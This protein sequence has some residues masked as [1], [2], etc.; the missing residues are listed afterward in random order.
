MSWWLCQMEEAAQ[1]QELRKAMVP[2]AQPIMRG[3]LAIC[4][5]AMIRALLR[6]ILE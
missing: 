6:S 3:K 2:K 1:I 5:F 4:C